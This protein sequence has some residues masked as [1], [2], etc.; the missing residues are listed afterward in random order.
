M[1]GHLPYVRAMGRVLVIV[2]LVGLA[3]AAGVARAETAA[4]PV[5]LP[6]QVDTTAAVDRAA[7]QVVVERG[8]H[9]WKMSARHLGQ[10]ASDEEIAPYWVEVIDTNLHRLRSGDADLIYPGESIEMPVVSGRP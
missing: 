3:M 4:D 6:M 2:T 10:D 9:L 5:R 7:V 1:H 8:D